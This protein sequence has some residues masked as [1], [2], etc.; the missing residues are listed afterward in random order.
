MIFLL[1]AFY[2]SVAAMV[3]TELIAVDWEEIK[4][5]VRLQRVLLVLFC[6]VLATVWP[7]VLFELLV[8]EIR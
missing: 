2:A 3:F 6:V 7:I 1:L 8:E 4:V 5:S